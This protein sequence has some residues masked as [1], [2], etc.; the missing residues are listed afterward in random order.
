MSHDPSAITTVDM[1]KD[2]FLILENFKAGWH[3]RDDDSRIPLGGARV[4]RNMTLTERG[5]ISP[6]PGEL[7]IGDAEDGSGGRTLYSFRKSDRTSLLLKTYGTNLK[8]YS[9][10]KSRWALIK[11]DFT[12]DQRFGFKEAR[13]DSTDTLDYLY[14]GNAVEPFFRWCGYDAYL[15]SAVLAGATSIPVDTTLKTDVYES[16]T[17]SASTTTSI[18]IATS[19]WANNIWNG[20]YVRITSGAQ[21]GKISLI[22]ATTANSIT[23][24]TITGLSGTPTFEIR[25]LAV[26][27]TGTLVYNGQS[28]T[29]TGVPT[30]ASLTVGSAHASAGADDTVTTGVELYPAAPKG[31]IFE[32]LYEALYVA[33]IK[34]KPVTVNRSHNADMDNFT[35]SS[36]RAADEADLV[37]FPYGGGSIQDLKVWEEQMVVLKDDAIETLAYSQEYD[38]STQSATDI[39]QQK[40]I[41]SGVSIGSQGQ[42]WR[43]EDDLVFVTPDKRLTSLGR[44]L[45]KDIRPQTKDLA[46]TIRREMK[47]YDFSSVRGCEYINQMFVAAKSGTDVLAN[48]RMLVWNKDYGT[49]ESSWNIQAADSTPHDGKLYYLDA[50]SP[51]VYQMLIG[52]NK[53]KGDDT[54]PLTCSW[55]SG[56]INGKGTAFYLNEISSLAIEGRIRLNTTINFQLFKDYSSLSFAD[57]SIR[58]Q[59]ETIDGE[60]VA[61]FLGGVG[62]GLEPLGASSFLGDEEDDGYRHFVVFVD[63]PTTQVEY[64]SIGVGSDGTNQGWEVL[65]MGLNATENVFEAQN[66]ITETS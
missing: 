23:F 14:G 59:S 5:G 10:K 40:T 50:F 13:V 20:F 22:S 62:L 56:W 38:P 64:V 44:V 7:L 25:Q 28:I 45:N 36:P 2:Q 1:A 63:F 12:A 9:R 24:A 65:R 49:W 52:T 15:T 8:F 55:L 21:T 46:Y 31:N 16:G 60:E 34:N 66:R 26:P 57:I 17:A 32:T 43:T 51:N 27:A 54:Y 37:Y 39:A 4:S 33:G 41:K 3:K 29:Y 53:I 61:S 11:G 30:D 48:D 35:I 19:D 58:A 47:T 6:R 42:A 18:T